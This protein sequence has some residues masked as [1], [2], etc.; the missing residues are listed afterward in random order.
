MI[1]SSV[2]SKSTVYF[3]LFMMGLIPLNASLAA[4][5]SSWSAGAPM[6]IAKSE[7]VGAV[8]DDKVYIIGGF[9]KNG[10]STTVETYDPVAD[11][12]AFSDPLPRPLDHA[13]AASFNG[14][15]YVVGGGYLDREEL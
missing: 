9:D 7:I 6:P 11:K 1:M 15:L 14:K 13:A 2:A 10:S 3:L 8:L 5:E 12:W 4:V